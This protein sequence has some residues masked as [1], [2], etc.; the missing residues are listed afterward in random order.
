MLASSHVFYLFLLCQFNFITTPAHWSCFAYFY[1][2]FWKFVKYLFV[3]VIVEEQNQVEDSGKVFMF[4]SY[5]IACTHKWH[6]NQNVYKKNRGSTHNHNNFKVI[7]LKKPAISISTVSDG[8]VVPFEK[9]ER[10]L[11]KPKLKRMQETF[12]IPQVNHAKM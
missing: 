9:F 12:S 8:F 7:L 11:K 3:V 6:N 5:K 10:K 2:F 1:V 4:H